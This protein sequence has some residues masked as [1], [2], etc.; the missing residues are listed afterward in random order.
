[1]R[2][3]SDCFEAEPAL[4]TDGDEGW[5]AVYLESRDRYE[6]VFTSS[7]TALICPAVPKC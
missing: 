5:F 2:T 7:K 3:N 1:M 6:V 4:D